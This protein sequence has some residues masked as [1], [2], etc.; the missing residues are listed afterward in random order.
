ME[1]VGRELHLR[2]GNDLWDGGKGLKELGLR[3]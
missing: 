1:S 3:E 2:A